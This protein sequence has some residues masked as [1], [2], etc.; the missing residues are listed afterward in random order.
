MN[1]ANPNPLIDD[2]DMLL[3][4]QSQPQKLPEI[5]QSGQQQISSDLKNVKPNQQDALPLGFVKTGLG[6][7]KIMMAHI[8]NLY[9]GMKAQ[10]DKAIRTRTVVTEKKAD[11]HKRPFNQAWFD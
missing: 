7:S 5:S 8:Y 3:G 6:P 1:H 2:L 9:A 11:L 10:R 4:E